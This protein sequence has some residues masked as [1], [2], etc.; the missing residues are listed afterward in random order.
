VEE[1]VGAIDVREGVV[2]DEVACSG[3]HGKGLLDPPELGTCRR[4][5]EQ[6]AELEGRLEDGAGL[7]QAVEAVDRFLELPRRNRRLRARDHAPGP[8]VLG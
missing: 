2:V 1:D 6:G 5:G 4:P 7:L 3:E 8:L